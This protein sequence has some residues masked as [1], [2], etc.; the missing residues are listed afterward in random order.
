MQLTKISFNGI[1]DLKTEVYFYVF[2][3][4]GLTPQTMQLFMHMATTIIAV[5]NRCA[6]RPSPHEYLYALLQLDA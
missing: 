6:T 1:L 2:M 5:Q 3:K 4:K